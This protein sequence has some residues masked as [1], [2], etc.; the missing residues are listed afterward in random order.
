MST[1]DVFQHAMGLPEPDRAALA[2]QLLQSL[3]GN[4]TADSDWSSAWTSE[5][6]NRLA[7][8]AS[9]NFSARDWREA[10]ADARKSR[11]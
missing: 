4:D 3:E 7:K 1:N 5:I 2:H 9:G 8:V 11:R 10:V 6:E